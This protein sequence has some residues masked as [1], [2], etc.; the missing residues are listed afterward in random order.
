MHVCGFSCFGVR[1][2][3]NSA[4]VS[5]S[6]FLLR[7]IGC[8]G[9]RIGRFGVVYTVCKERKIGQIAK[10]ALAIGTIEGSFLS[11]SVRHVRVKNP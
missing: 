1:I 2:V 10:F 5:F 8:C 11:C 4:D 3:G 6:L 7:W 9:S